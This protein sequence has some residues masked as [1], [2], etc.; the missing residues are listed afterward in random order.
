MLFSPLK[1]LR[2]RICS[3]AQY[4]QKNF[5][6]VL[7]LSLLMRMIWEKEK[8]IKSPFMRSLHL[9]NACEMGKWSRVGNK[10]TTNTE[11]C[12]NIMNASNALSSLIP[13]TQIQDA[14]TIFF[15]LVSHNEII[16]R[17]FSQ[18]LLS[19]TSRLYFQFLC[20]FP[21]LSFFFYGYYYQFIWF[22]FV[23]LI[24]LFASVFTSLLF[25]SSMSG[26]HLSCMCLLLSSEFVLCGF[27]LNIC[28]GT[29]F[30]FLVFSL[31]TPM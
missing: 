14:I 8:A 1:L 27:L 10:L 12:Q 7:F 3:M 24:I 15:L 18:F 13:R 19:W 11:A 4:I 25:L 20:S 30:I 21:H 22:R 26:L 28:T 29:C 9:S 5:E 16:I 17:M 6:T 31:C 23:S 2:P